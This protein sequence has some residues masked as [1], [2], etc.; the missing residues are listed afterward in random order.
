MADRVPQGTGARV[1]LGGGIGA[2][3]S[4]VAALL[5]SANFQVVNADD[6]GRAVLEAGTSASARVGEMWPGVVEDGGINRA[7]LARI[8]FSNVTELHRLEAVTHPAIVDEIRGIVERCGSD[9]LVV[10]TPVPALLADDDF[11]RVVVFADRD[12]RLERSVGRGNDADD[13]VRRMQ[14]QPSDVEWQE[15]ADHR[16]DNTGT[17][18]DTEAAVADLV[19]EVKRHG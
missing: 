1:L 17:P 3:K 19:L 10:E 5:G 11:V 14:A 18:E 7:A 9:D 2:G 15:W 6:I 12:T 8:V 13:T 16:I 4:T